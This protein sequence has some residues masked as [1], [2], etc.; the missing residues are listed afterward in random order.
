LEFVLTGDYA[1][2]VTA[3][4]G[5][6]FGMYPSVYLYNGADAGQEP[7][8]E[9]SFEADNDRKTQIAL[10]GLR[11]GY[12]LTLEITDDGTVDALNATDELREE[13]SSLNPLSTGAT[14]VVTLDKNSSSGEVQI[15][16]KV[17]VIEW[18]EDGE[19]DKEIVEV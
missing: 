10:F 11:E 1:T 2:G 18:I 6:L 4:K 16:N 19:G 15:T 13:L 3:V 14:A 8:A 12:G 7:A 5:V 9:V 17:E